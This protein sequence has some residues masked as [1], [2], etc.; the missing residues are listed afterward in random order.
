MTNDFSGRIKTMLAD[1]KITPW[2]ESIGLNK[3]TTFRMRKNEVPGH[4]ILNLIQK[5]ENLSLSW[6]LDGQGA[7]FLV[8]RFNSDADLAAQLREL[9]AEDG[10]RVDW[11][12]DTRGRVAIALTMPGQ[13]DFK[14]KAVDYMIT[15][16]LT[17]PAGAQ[18]VALLNNWP[19]KYRVELAPEVMDQLL[20]GE[21]GSYL[22]GRLSGD[23]EPVH[24]VEWNN[25]DLVAEP[26]SRYGEQV[27]ARFN[28]LTPH[29]QESIRMIIETLL[30]Q[31][32]RQ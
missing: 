29:N 28:E 30:E 6:L 8:Q 3:G 18:T 11:I 26:P 7:P 9:F 5:V 27:L 23:A 24:H 12:E 16:L 13:I 4:Q 10:W 15:E 25:E 19:H 31:Q 14:G 20:N 22:L 17:G 1:R 32:Q 2:G 21:I